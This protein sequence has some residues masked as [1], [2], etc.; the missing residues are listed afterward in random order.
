M[1]TPAISGTP[2]PAAKTS[3]SGQS[4]FSK[5]RMCRNRR[6]RTSIVESVATTASL[7][8]SVV[9]RTCWTERNLTS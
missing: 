3:R 7:T 8:T 1:M 4:R 9:R 6:N 2:R 5:S